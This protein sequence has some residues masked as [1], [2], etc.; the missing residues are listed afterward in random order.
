MNEE[1]EKPGQHF[2]GLGPRPET[3][4]EE[5]KKK[6]SYIS[7]GK[8]NEKPKSRNGRLP[9]APNKWGMTRTEVEVIKFLT[10]GMS[11]AQVAKRMSLSNK[12]IATYMGR[13][14]ERM[15]VDNSIAAV[16]VWD[17]ETW[18]RPVAVHPLTVLRTML[19]RE[20]N[21]EEKHLN[22]D[23]WER[24]PRVYDSLVE[25]TRRKMQSATGQ[26]DEAM[27]ERI[28]NWFMTTTLQRDEW[29]SLLAAIRGDAT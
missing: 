15:G 10:E 12:T 28:Q 16:L 20:P 14:R 11:P 24:N 2:I 4:D 22:F 8:R 17:R 25:N 29:E 6:F 18:Q 3:R 13:I 5:P 26:L 27:F 1:E 7:S 19:G 23:N 9:P 21:E